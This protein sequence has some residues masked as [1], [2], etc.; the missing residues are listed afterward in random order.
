MERTLDGTASVAV[1]DRTD[2]AL[3]GGARSD[4]GNTCI[5]VRSL[6]KVYGDKPERALEPEHASKGKSALLAELG[7]VTALQD[8]AF[9]VRR[10]ETF[11]VMGLSGSGKSTLVR[12]LVRLIEPTEGRVTLDGEDVTALDA[13]LLRD[14]RANMQLVFQDPF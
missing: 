10:G 8:V 1:A 3:D 5:S 11:V 7:L 13:T 4:I 9:D 12:C 14:L 2:P 6:W